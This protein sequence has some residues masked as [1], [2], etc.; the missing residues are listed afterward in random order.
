MPREED[1][2]EGQEEADPGLKRMLYLARNEWGWIAVGLVMLFFG[3]VP[4]LVMPI[5]FGRVIDDIAGNESAEK[6]KAAVASHLFQLL[7]ILGFGAVASIV[8]SIIFNGGGERVVAR[9]RVRLFRAIIQQEIALF[10]RRKT[11]ELLSR[12]TS[13]TTSLQDVATSN[14]SMFV[15]G[16]S[17][18]LFSVVL[19]FYTSWQLATLVISVVPA[20]VLAISAYSRILKRLSTRYS[21]ALGHASDVAQQSVAN[22]RTVRSFAAEDIEARKYEIAVGNPDDEEGNFKCWYPSG[23]MSSYKA[24]M[25]KQFAGATFQAFVTLIG[26]GAIVAVIWFGAYQVIDG[27]LSKGDLITFILYSVQIAASFGMISGL[28]ASL[29]SAKGAAKRTFQL[30]DRTPKVPVRGGHVPDHMDGMIRFENVNFVYP[31]RRDVTVLKD[32][33]LDIPKNAKVAFVGS[34]GAGKS[35]VL[36]LIQRFYDVDSGRILIDGNP[37]DTLDPSWVRRHFAFVQQEPALFGATIGKNIAYGYAVRMGSPEAMPSQ[38][39]LEAAARDAYAHD[40]I[41]A[42]PDGYDTLVGERGVRLSGGQKQRVAIAR[43]LL[44]DPR[45]LLLDEATSALDS[46]S[47]AIVARAIEKAMVGRTTLI[48]AHRLST[49]QNADMIVLIDQGC[50]VDIGRHGELLARCEKYRD[51]V[52]KQL[53]SGH[54]AAEEGSNGRSTA[55]P[56]PEAARESTLQES[57]PKKASNGQD[58]EMSGRSTVEPGPEA[59]PGASRGSTLQGSTPKKASNDQDTEMTRIPNPDGDDSM[60]QGLLR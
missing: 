5:F 32:F 60:K 26:S 45:V 14:I 22:I 15:R 49:V 16:L 41:M 59:G 50:I 55:E 46:E 25:Q 20:C 7:V 37:L 33:T 23:V 24:G 27:R 34:S 40:F 54:V 19:M 56:T 42:F 10:D 36:S 51:L 31:S 48:V 38:D 47:E 4:F 21:D 57:T 35:T 6:K 2:E 53:M 1:L 13:D 30:I 58:T 29:F 17:Q 43:A 3:M 28:V 52:S 39:Q 8:R 44:M 11:G 9:L 18:V 12:L